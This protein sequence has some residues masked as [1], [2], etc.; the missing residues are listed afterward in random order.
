MSS[1]VSYIIRMEYSHVFLNN[2]QILKD[3]LNMHR[4]RDQIRLMGK[5]VILDSCCL[6]NE[7][8][9]SIHKKYC[10]KYCCRKHRAIYKEK[11]TKEHKRKRIKHKLK[12]KTS[13]TY[14]SSDEEEDE[15]VKLQLKTSM[16]DKKDT[17]DEYV[18]FRCVSLFVR[19]KAR[20]KVNTIWGKRK[21][22]MG[23]LKRLRAKLKLLEE[24]H[25]KYQKLVRPFDFLNEN[26]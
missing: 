7:F 15:H 4:E 3:F 5:L 18:Y 13:G 22:K 19:N 24:E 14:C 1:D 6:C 25:E 26:R 8:W 2:A 10:F 21:P 20:Q 9:E 11:G 12:C 23:V 16:M 17:K